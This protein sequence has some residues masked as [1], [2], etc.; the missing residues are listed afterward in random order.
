M[1]HH[2]A[3]LNPAFAAATSNLP[4]A[5]SHLIEAPLE[6]IHN[7]DALY[8]ND[9]EIDGPYD[10]DLIPEEQFYDDTDD[11]SLLA[12]ID[13]S[14]HDNVDASQELSAHRW[15]WPPNAPPDDA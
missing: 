5:R 4:P 2:L 14:Y 6:P 9:D 7:H 11:P 10:D 1:I 15:C 12:A 13:A 8:A 3:A